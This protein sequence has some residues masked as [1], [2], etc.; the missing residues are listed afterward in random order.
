MH[1]L[2]WTFTAAPTRRRCDVQA[3]KCTKG[4]GSSRVVHLCSGGQTLLTM[5]GAP[6]PCWRFFVPSV[7]QD[8]RHEH[9]LWSSTAG[10][11]GVEPVQEST[12]HRRLHQAWW[13]G[14]WRGGRKPSWL[15]NETEKTRCAP[16][17][18]SL[19]CR[20]KAMEYVLWLSFYELQA[21]RN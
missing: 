10:G 8:T 11:V 17:P 15:A 9:A 6:A 19:Y 13:C 7:L 5:F 18:L 1:K 21:Q 16:A 3:G 2:V 4:F 14:R 12:S 20:S